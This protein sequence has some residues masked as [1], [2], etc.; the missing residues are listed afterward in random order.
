MSSEPYWRAPRRLRELLEAGTLTPTEYGLVH[1]LAEAGADRSDGTAATYEQLV[2]LF[3][4]SPKTVARAFVKLAALELV[5]HDLRQGQRRPFR[6]R[7][8][9]ALMVRPRTLPQV[10]EVLSEVAAE[11]RLRTLTPPPVS[12]VTSDSDGNAVGRNPAV[13]AASE[14]V[15]TSDS[16]RA[17][18]ETRNQVKNKAAAGIVRSTVEAYCSAGGSLELDEWRAALA[19]H[20]STLAKSGLS[21]R[22]ILA[23]ARQLGRERSFP[24]YLTQRAKQLEQA[25]GPCSWGDS[26]RSRLTAAQL[27]ECEC[28]RCSEWLAFV[29]EEAKA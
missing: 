20:A 9:E 14:A 3:G 25:G 4:V 10:S 6:V 12:E 1:Y 8:G 24:G 5:S 22:L 26:D 27:T 21:D 16:P 2:A 28:N 11:T 13:E 7:P 19:R 17:R 29:L 15:L 18:G 23:A